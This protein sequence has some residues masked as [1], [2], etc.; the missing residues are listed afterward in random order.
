MDSSVEPQEMF[1]QTIDDLLDAIGAN[2]ERTGSIKGRIEMLR[3]QVENGASLEEVVANE[4]SPL[5]IELITENINAL[6]EVGAR[7]RWSEASMLRDE[8]M[9]AADIARLFGVSRQRVSALLNS[10]PAAVGDQT[11]S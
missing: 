10:P 5:I 9:T 2:L 7:L 6:Q 11:H 8:G 1:L 4:P 3:R